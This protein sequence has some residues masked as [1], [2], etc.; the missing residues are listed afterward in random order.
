M[1]GATDYLENALFGLLF[2][3]A[4]IANLGDATGVRG[5]TGVGSVY[6]SLW[7]VTPTDVAASGTETVYTN[8]ARVAVV[9]SSGGWTIAG[10]TA[11]TLSNAAA[12][13]FPTCGAT[14]ATI[15][16]FGIHD[17]LTT[18]NLLTFGACSLAVSNAITPSFAIGALTTTLV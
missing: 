18:G 1:A 2:Q 10:A 16:A 4:N 8:Y 14:G 9:R 13:S 12:I 7:T 5:S 6:V 3:N 11:K 17:A 15:V